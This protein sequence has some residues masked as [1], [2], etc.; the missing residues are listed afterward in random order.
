MDLLIRH[1]EDI[2]IALLR[3]SLKTAWARQ[4]F[5][6]RDQRIYVLYW[7]AVLFYFPLCLFFPAWV[8]VAGPLVWGIPHIFASFRMTHFAL[9]G[10][11]TSASE[12][13]KT[14]PSFHFV[15]F[16]W[17]SVTAYRVGSELDLF[18]FTYFEIYPYLPEILSMM[19]TFLG[20]CFI[21]KFNFKKK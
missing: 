5:S 16:I 7:A 9:S 19:A 18:H 20:L 11:S 12:S 8:L 13:G 3:L 10:S 17:L 1:L 14:S 15:S 2:R 6:N 4:V 21:H